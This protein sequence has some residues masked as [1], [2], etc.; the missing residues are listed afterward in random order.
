ML[1]TIA[2]RLL[3][4]PNA[5]LAR[6]S[7][8]VGGWCGGGERQSLRLWGALSIKVF[9]EYGQLMRIAGHYWLHASSLNLKL[10]FTI[11]KLRFL[12][13]DARVSLPRPH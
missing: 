10:I 11:N 8:R 9:P 2:R 5:R 12:K 4:Q 6:Q 1:D 7:A 13:P 3:E